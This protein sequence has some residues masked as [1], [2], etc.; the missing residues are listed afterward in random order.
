M[1]MFSHLSWFA[2]TFLRVHCNQVMSNKASVSYASAVQLLTPPGAAFITG[3]TSQA[4][5][6][7]AMG[8]LASL[9]SVVMQAQ[10]VATM[11]PNRCPFGHLSR[12]FADCRSLPL[13]CTTQAW[14]T[15]HGHVLALSFLCHLS[16]CPVLTLGAEAGSSSQRR[17]GGP[18]TSAAVAS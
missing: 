16:H 5:G 15:T 14:S 1:H 10:L 4:T 12:C 3:C 2:V 6:H 7:I 8:T 9:H 18:E 11:T 13:R 17:V